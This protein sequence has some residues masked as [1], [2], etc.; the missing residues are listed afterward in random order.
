MKRYR[1]GVAVLILATAVSMAVASWTDNF[2]SYAAGQWPS[3][4]WIPS[5]NGNGSIVTDVKHG[6]EKSF[7]MY[8]VIG[9]YWATLAHRYIGNDAAYA[10]DFWIRNGNEPIPGYGHQYRGSID[11]HTQANWVPPAARIMDWDRYGQVHGRGG[12]LLG[13]YSTLTWYHV[14]V[15]YER[16]ATAVHMEYWIDGVYKGEENLPASP[17]EMDFDYFALTAQAGTVWFD[18]VSV[19]K[20]DVDATVDFDPDMLN[21]KSRGNWVTCYIELP[22]GYSVR[23][24]ELATVAISR[25]N[26]Q[27]L[28]QPLYREG[29]TGIGD[30]DHDEI[31]DLMVKFDRQELIAILEGMGI[32]GGDQVELTVIGNLT[33]GRTF[34][35]SDVI[36][37]VETGDGQEG[38][39]AGLPNGKRQTSLEVVPFGNAFRLSYTLATGGNARLDICDMTGRLIRTLVDAQQPS[40]RHD[41]TWN[42]TDGSGR[43]LPKGAYFATM[44]AGEFSATRKMVKSE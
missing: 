7:R 8:G 4:N 18:D 23:D 9:S 1:G 39:V 25:I 22:G 42:G 35:G 13:T 41:V 16:A 43:K 21:L 14:K 5:G 19:T 34:A 11:L 38:D 15:L 32:K 2:E 17:S 40:G 33:G 29:P 12:L 20:P 28:V 31:P 10:I 6:G 27:P 37:I 30:Y 26:G 36:A 24:I 44:R 3:P